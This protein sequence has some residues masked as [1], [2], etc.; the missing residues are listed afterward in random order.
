MSTNRTWAEP[1]GLFPARARQE[2]ELLV[3]ERDRYRAALEFYA[4]ADSYE[5]EE[6]PMWTRA[7]E[8][9]EER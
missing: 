8:A 2:M 3:G 5:L 1:E 6:R 4:D 9:L 7:R